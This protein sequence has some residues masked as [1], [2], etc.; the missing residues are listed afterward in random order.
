MKNTAA[1]QKCKVPLVFLT[2]LSVEKQFIDAALNAFTQPQP[3]L[4]HGIPNSVAPSSANSVDR[5]LK[6]MMKESNV[7]FKNIYIF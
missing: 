1:F 2:F 6:G 7:K 4:G 3:V 5:L